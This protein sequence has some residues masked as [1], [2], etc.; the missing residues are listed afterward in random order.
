MRPLSPDASIRWGLLRNWFKDINMAQA[1]TVSRRAA[2]I[3][4]RAVPAEGQD[5]N[6]AHVARE[7]AELFVAD[8]ERSLRGQ[9]AP[10][11]VTAKFHA[12]VRD[13]LEQRFATMLVAETSAAEKAVSAALPV[14]SLKPSEVIEHGLVALSIA[15]LY[16]S[17]EARRFY[18]IRPRGQ[19]NGRLFPAWQFVDAVPEL[20]PDVLEKFTGTLETEV[21]AFFVTARD[22]LNELAPAELLAGKMFK[23]RG[24]PHASQ[25]RLLQLPAIERQQRVIDAIGQHEEGVAY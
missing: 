18:C 8:I 14:V 3:K 2:G 23:G 24:E 21:H 12:L 16:R 13:A 9:V 6:P 10:D 5:L 17:V 19:A 22:E 7:F 20:L 25:R 15:S 11:L 4:I 1:N